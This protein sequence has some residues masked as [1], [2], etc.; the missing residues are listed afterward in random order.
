MNIAYEIKFHFFQILSIALI[1]FCQ[2][3]QTSAD[4]SSNELQKRF[5]FSTKIISNEIPITNKFLLFFKCEKDGQM[6][7]KSNTNWSLLSN[8][9]I[10]TRNLSKS[11][12]LEFHFLFFRNFADLTIT[13][14]SITYNLWPLLLLFFVLYL[15]RIGKDE[16][17]FY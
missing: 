14:G 15:I 1:L 3:S 6:V 4:S 8:R 16:S 11:I 5:D 12:Q 17:L 7:T 10:K 9:S 2:S 13:D